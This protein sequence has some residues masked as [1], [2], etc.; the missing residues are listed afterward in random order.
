MRRQQ[1]RAF[2]VRERSGLAS[3]SPW[4]GGQAGLSTDPRAAEWERL[5]SEQET[6]GWVDRHWSQAHVGSGGAQQQVLLQFLVLSPALQPVH[7]C[8]VRP[9]LWASSAQGPLPP[10]AS[11]GLERRRAFFLLNK[12]FLVDT[13]V[14]SGVWGMTSEA[15]AGITQPQPS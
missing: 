14:A 6:P 10:L 1:S 13:H 4:D 9:S 5:E 3:C 7:G 8:T 12:D 15:A 2:Q 11:Q